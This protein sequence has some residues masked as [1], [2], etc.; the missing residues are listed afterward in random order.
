MPDAAGLAVGFLGTRTWAESL[1]FCR[2]HPEVLG[3]D[4]DGALAELERRLDSEGDMGGRDAVVQARATLAA[5]RRDGLELGFASAELEQARRQLAAAEG[6]DRAKR[7][8]EVGK[9]WYGRFEVTGDPGD[10]HYAVDFARQAVEAAPGDDAALADLAGVEESGSG[11]RRVGGRR[12]DGR[13][14]AGSGAGRA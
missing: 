5:C 13:A 11:V 2:D 6:R 10:L 14:S 7:L 8:T 4:V 12:S 1:Q 9:A 3:D